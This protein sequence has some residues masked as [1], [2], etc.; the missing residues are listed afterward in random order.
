MYIQHGVHLRVQYIHVHVMQ[1]SL[2]CSQLLNFLRIVENDLAPRQL[3]GAETGAD[4][5]GGHALSP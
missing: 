1:H 3:G 2:R 4:G 5:S